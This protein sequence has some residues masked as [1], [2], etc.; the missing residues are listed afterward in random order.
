MSAVTPNTEVYLLKCPL[1]LDNQNQLD[2]AT[3]SAQEAYFKG[4]PRLYLDEFSYQRKDSVIRVNRHI[5]TLL[6][7]TYVMYKNDN[8]SNKWFYAFITDME[9]IN[10]NCTYV[11][12]K[13]DVWQTWQFDLSWKKCFV[14]REHTNDDTFGKNLVPESL[15]TG[16]YVVNKE[17]NLRYND[18]EGTPA[19]YLVFMQVTELPASWSLPNGCSK[20]VNN[21]GSGCYYVGLDYDATG[22][23]AV[24]KIL[25][26]YDSND[27]AGAVLALFV[28]PELITP[29]TEVHKT[30][31]GL[32]FVVSFPTTSEAP[33]IMADGTFAMTQNLNGYSPKNKKALTYPYNYILVSNNNGETF[34]YRFEEFY[35]TND[36]TRKQIGTPSFT[37]LGALTQG[38]QIK[39]FPENYM[40][41]IGTTSCWDYG[42]NAGKYP[43]LSWTSDYYLNWQAENS[44]SMFGNYLAEQTA[45]GAIATIAGAA[46]NPLNLVTGGL[47]AMN[48]FGQI[49]NAVHQQAVAEMQP[50]QA[51]GNTQSGDLN[52]AF[53]KDQFTF[54]QMT[55]RE[56]FARKIDDYFSAYG[57]QTNEYKIPNR[58]GRANW[59]FVQ[60]KGCNITGNLPQKDIEEIK[61]MFN[62][63]IT[64]WHHPN[65]FMD[66]SQSNSIVS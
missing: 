55:V 52:F 1:E 9:Y 5:D 6:E 62:A 63:G 30:L 38:C 41:G 2:F 8:Y 27:K 7:Y 46:M 20:M 33:T 60:T 31:G 56:Q 43:I 45:T 48:V 64:I 42:V 3:K 23:K 57:Y 44:A 65:T 26:W 39:M 10:D 19:E 15:E 50:K 51:K 11:T 61:G 12:I 13:T 17:M 47:A 29:V 66:Y 36:S 37:V 16:E 54:R 59:N 28:A 22:M 40:K 35:N 49:N 25:E 14:S 18:Y 21:V 53:S 24:S 4:L 34:E 32:Q 58:T